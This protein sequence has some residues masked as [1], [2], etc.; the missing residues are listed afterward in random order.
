MTA[1]VRWTI[2]KGVFL[3]REPAYL[4]AFSCTH[5]NNPECNKIQLERVIPHPGIF[6][7]FSHRE[8]I[9]LWSTSQRY[10]Q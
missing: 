8:V 3:R 4:A 10:Q 5:S 9:R 7:Y 6:Q 2:T 1:L